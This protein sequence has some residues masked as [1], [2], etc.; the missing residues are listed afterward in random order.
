[1]EN[2][3]GAHLLYSC[4]GIEPVFY[5]KVTV[6]T[7]TIKPLCPILAENNIDHATS[8]DTDSIVS[9]PLNLLNSTRRHSPA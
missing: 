9:R 2:L 5:D 1:M 6:N 3:T 7:E 8:A 4:K